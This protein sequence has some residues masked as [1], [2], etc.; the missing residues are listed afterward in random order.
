MTCED[1][2]AATL[3]FGGRSLNTLGRVFFK[4]LLAG[5][6]KIKS[7]QGFMVRLELAEG[8]TF[9]HCVGHWY[10]FISL[11]PSLPSFYLSSRTR[12]VALMTLEY[13]VCMCYIGCTYPQTN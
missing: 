7:F 6:G 13:I 11:S 2:G 10:I 5:K 8:C 3:A 4:D 1:N 9:I 12:T